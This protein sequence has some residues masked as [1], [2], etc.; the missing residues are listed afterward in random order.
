MSEEEKKNERK[1]TSPSAIMGGGGDGC[2]L[3]GVGNRRVTEA[4]LK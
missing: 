1:I 3:P 2:L 4:S